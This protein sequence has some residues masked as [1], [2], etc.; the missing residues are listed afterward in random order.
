MKKIMLAILFA[1]FMLSALS[2]PSYSQ[3]I[4]VS[5][6]D[7]FTYETHFSYN[8]TMSPQVPYQISNFTHWGNATEVTRTVTAVDGTTVTFEEEWTWNNGSS[9]TTNSLVVEVN[10]NQSILSIPVIDSDA[11]LG[12]QVGY[13]SQWTVG[14]VTVT[15]TVDWGYETET[16]ECNYHI[17]STTTFATVN[18]QLWWDADT[19]ILVYHWITTT[20]VSGDQSSY[21]DVRLLLIETSEWDIPEFPT[22]TALLLVFVA[23]TVSI[24]IYRRKKL[25]L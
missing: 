2:V 23:V 8:S 25:K 9:P 14:P 22:G 4:G 10:D 21:G 5:V 3:T 11:G 13:D 15:D 20:Y 16:R 7:W 12:D 6:G 1:T 17:S 18:R 19:G 24:D